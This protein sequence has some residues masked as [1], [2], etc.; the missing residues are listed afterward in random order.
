MNL[1]EIK[2]K[3]YIFTA[4]SFIRKYVPENLLTK[5]HTKVQETL[6]KTQTKIQYKE[7]SYTHYTTQCF[8]RYS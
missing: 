2:S 8:E 1:P 6:A 7:H 5:T 4:T 3:V